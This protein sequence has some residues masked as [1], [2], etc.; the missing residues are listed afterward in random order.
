MHGCVCYFIFAASSSFAMF[1]FPPRSGEIVFSISWWKVFQHEC[2]ALPL[3]RFM[4]LLWKANL[5]QCFTFQ[6]KYFRFSTFQQNKFVFFRSLKGYTNLPHDKMLYVLFFI[7]VFWSIR[8]LATFTWQ[9]HAI[10]SSRQTSCFFIILAKFSSLVIVPQQL[11]IS[12]PFS[13]FINFF[14]FFPML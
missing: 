14:V 6:Q 8:D 7:F 2:I 4:I 11:S 12:K 9:F 3:S 1:G 5:K 13:M 10:S